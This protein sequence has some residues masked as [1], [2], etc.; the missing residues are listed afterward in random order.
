MPEILTFETIR[1]IHKD[2]ESSV[3]LSKIPE[4]FFEKA[5]EYVKSKEEAGKNDPSVAQ[6]FQNV[7]HRLMFIMEARERKIL[8]MALYSVRTGLPPENLTVAEKSFFENILTSLKNFKQFREDVLEPKINASL[9]V[10]AL[11]ED[12]EAFLG[13]DMISY[14]P[15]KKGDI[16]SIPGRNADILIE[17]KKAEFMKTE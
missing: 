5:K 15:F 7:K 1:K 12:I 6:E 9:K 16:A 11:I 17:G 2:E 14:G 4:D 3:K 13:E 8:N 10:V